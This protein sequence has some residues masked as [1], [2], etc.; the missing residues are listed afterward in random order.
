MKQ[1]EQIKNN[2][3]YSSQITDLVINKVLNLKAIN[4]PDFNTYNEEFYDWL[5]GFTDG[6]GSFSTQLRTNNK[7]S[8]DISRVVF[9]YGIYLHIDDIEVLNFIKN[10]L[11]LNNKIYKLNRKDGSQRCQLN[12]SDFKTLKETILPIFK[13]KLNTKKYHDF[14]IWCDMIELYT[15]KN[16]KFK[17]KLNDLILLRSK[18][19]NYD[20]KHNDDLLDIKLNMNWY[21][22]FME[23]EGSYS[24][25]YNENLNKFTIVSELSQREESYKLFRYLK[26][27]LFNLE[28]D[29]N[30]KYNINNKIN[31][32]EYSKTNK[33]KLTIASID[34]FYWKYIP[35]IVKYNWNS[36]KSIDMTWFMIAVIILK[37]G[38]H[39]TKLGKELLLFITNN[40]NNNRYYINKD[41]DINKILEVLAIKPIYDVNQ[42]QDLN[43]KRIG[44]KLSKDIK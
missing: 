30:C 10:K 24:V 13:S 31:I 9:N 26:D 36:R 6:E 17:D 14:N 12:I 23:G 8:K 20:Y 5:V 22:G 35:N 4:K 7:N 39:Y 28:S 38:L 15:N 18:L 27:Y 29:I 2:L 3:G 11:N 42:T 16:I 32:V 33:I 25:K 21:I 1:L 40:M 37:H 44:R 34:Y 19:N 41:I 43:G